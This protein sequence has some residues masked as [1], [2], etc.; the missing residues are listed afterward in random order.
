M[1]T[2]VCLINTTTDIQ[3][4]LILIKEFSITNNNIVIPSR[5]TLV[6]KKAKTINQFDNGFNGTPVMNANY[7]DTDLMCRM[8]VQKNTKKASLEQPIWQNMQQMLQKTIPYS[9]LQEVLTLVKQKV[10]QFKTTNK[11]NENK[12]TY[13]W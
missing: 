8:Y 7:T 3:D 11:I 1:Y 6:I 2:N 9:I 12:I 10:I 4:Q 13:L 5:V